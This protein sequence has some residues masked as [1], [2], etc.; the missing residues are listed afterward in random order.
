M[1]RLFQILKAFPSL[2]RLYIILFDRTGLQTVD[3]WFSFELFNGF[4]QQLTHL[5]LGF[6]EKPLNESVL[7]D[8]EIYLPKLQ[9]LC[10]HSPL[11]A[12]PK[13]MT[14]MADILSRLSSLQT[15]RLR[16]DREVDYQP[17]EDMIIEKCLKIRT[18]EPFYRRSHCFYYV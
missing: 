5:S 2:K 4:P 1:E 7:K 8:I 9:E 6:C 17:M 18:I 15:I 12:D 14:E 16:F 13:G 3:Q 10:F 11:K